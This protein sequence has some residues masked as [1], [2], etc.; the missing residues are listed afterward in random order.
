MF[1]LN[2]E[3]KSS[4]LGFTITLSEDEQSV[5]DAPLV[6]DENDR[7]K[8]KATVVFAALVEK[9]QSILPRIGIQHLSLCVADECFVEMYFCEPGSNEKD[10]MKYYN[11]IY[12]TLDAVMEAISCDFDDLH[13]IISIKQ[14]H[15]N[16]TQL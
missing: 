9:I 6:N 15:Y 12:P 10:S 2:D 8:R 7:Y 14:M 5:K 11:K 16:C 3:M 4:S 13:N 1:A